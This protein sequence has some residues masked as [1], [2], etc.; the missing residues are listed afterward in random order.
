M[1]KSLL[2]RC[3]RDCKSSRSAASVSSKTSSSPTY[4][5]AFDRPGIDPGIYAWYTFLLLIFTKSITKAHEH[6][7]LTDD[8]FLISLI[9]RGETVWINANAKHA[10]TFLSFQSG[11]FPLWSCI[12]RIFFNFPI[13]R[14]FIWNRSKWVGK[15]L[16]TNP[17]SFSHF[18][19]G[20]SSHVPLK[21][22]SLVSETELLTSWVLIEILI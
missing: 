18:N 11:S 7:H 20:L 14:V 6:F 1:S 9:S 17:Q 21:Y 15:Y 4:S 13:F 10:L 16:K 5:Q 19:W 12:T 2:W 8:I 22:D 3:S